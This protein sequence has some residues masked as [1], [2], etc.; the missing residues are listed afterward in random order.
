MKKELYSALLISTISGIPLLLAGPAHADG[1]VYWDSDNSPRAFSPSTVIIGP[2]EN[3]TWWNVDSY[4]FDLMVTFDGGFNFTVPW[5]QGMEITFPSRTG[6]YS[7]S[8]QIGDH[9]AV[10]IAVAPAVTIT[11]PN[12]NAVFPA[13]ATFTVQATASETSGDSVSHVQFFLDD[14]SGNGPSLIA[15][16]SSPPYTAGITNLDVGTY[17]LSAVAADANAGLTASDAITITVTPGANI[18]LGSPRMAPG[19]FLFDVTGLAVGKTNIVQVSTN[20]TSWTPVQT[21]IAASAAITLTNTAA[22]ARQFYRVLQ[23]P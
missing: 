20:L 7:Y 8:D 22:K 3:V 6:I 5:F 15:D 18:N 9:G 19:A 16:V 12:N 17:T 10:I 4:G 23:L 13:L 2:G 1:T 11:A 21:N 14:G